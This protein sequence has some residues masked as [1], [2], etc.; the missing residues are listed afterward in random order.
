MQGGNFLKI[1]Q[2]VTIRPLQEVS[3]V[4]AILGV[5]FKKLVRYTE[6]YGSNTKNS[7]DP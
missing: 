6:R 4:H 1:S 3:D 2:F 5:K 7:Q